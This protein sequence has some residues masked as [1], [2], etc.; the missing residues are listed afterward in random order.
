MIVALHDHPVTVEQNYFINKSLSSW[1]VNMFMGCSH[2]C[3]FCS[4]PDTST[5]KQKSTLAPFGVDDP[6]AEWGQYALLRPWDERK[7]IAS[8][9]K[10]EGT[11]PATLN[12]DGNR[13]VIFSSTTDPYQ[14]FPGS[15]GERR[16]FNE[17]ARSLIRNALTAIRDHSTLN[18][19]ILTRSP[20]ARSDFDLFKSFGN[21]LLLGTSLPTLDPTLSR[22]Y[23]GRSPAPR[24]RL[25][26]LLDAH[27]EGINTFVAVA[28]VFPECG[29]DGMLEVFQA[30]KAANPCTVFMEP[31]NLR[32]GNVDRIRLAAERMGKPIDMTPFTGEWSDYAISALQDAE[33]AAADAGI[34]DRLHLWPDHRALATK[35]VLARQKDPHAYIS[36]LNRWWKRVSEWPG[37]SY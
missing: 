7:F 18:V 37:S 19:R 27:A 1:A 32:R 21:R 9:M 35:A 6:I 10:A 11:D 31:I 17:H 5:G 34:V 33:R 23:E 36:W 29:Y 16:L 12:A 8:V 20:L 26:L 24:Q 14:V 30:V 2:G 22:I 28:P 4:V 13:A 15:Q 25:K 3:R